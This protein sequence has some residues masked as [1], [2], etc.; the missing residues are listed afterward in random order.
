[1]FLISLRSFRC[2]TLALGGHVTD[3]SPEDA[4]TGHR[5]TQPASTM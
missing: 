4:G 2:V 5:H 3:A 1:M